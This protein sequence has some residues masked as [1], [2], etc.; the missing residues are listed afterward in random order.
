MSTLHVL[1]T[2]TFMVKVVDCSLIGPDKTSKATIWSR[3]GGVISAI[4]AVF[5]LLL[6]GQPFG[7]A[8][9]AAMPTAATTAS[10]SAAAPPITSRRALP[11]CRNRGYREGRS[12]V[13]SSVDGALRFAAWRR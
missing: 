9:V 7:V 6:V 13:S 11:A 12:M 1:P 10:V 5:R 3:A 8:D 4:G 2:R